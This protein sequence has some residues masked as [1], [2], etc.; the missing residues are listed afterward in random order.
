MLGDSMIIFLLK[1]TAEW[2]RTL[3]S[4]LEGRFFIL[5]SEGDLRVSG[6]HLQLSG[7]CYVCVHRSVFPEEVS[8]QSSQ[9]YKEN[10]CPKEQ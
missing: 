8:H 2:I 10:S 4:V 6:D 3:T 9:M 7:Q 1:E 5:G